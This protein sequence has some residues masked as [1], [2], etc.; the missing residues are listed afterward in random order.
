MIVYMAGKIYIQLF[1]QNHSIRLVSK[2]SRLIFGELCLMIFF[3][4]MPGTTLW[5]W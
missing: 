5:H 3:F 2:S 1:V 4:L